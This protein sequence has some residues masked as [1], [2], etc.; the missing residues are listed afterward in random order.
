MKRTIKEVYGLIEEKLNNAKR[1]YQNEEFKYLGQKALLQGT[2]DAYQ[3]ILSLIESSHLLEEDKPIKGNGLEALERIGKEDLHSEREDYCFLKNVYAN[4]YNIIETALKEGEINKEALKI[5]ALVLDLNAHN[6]LV[7]S[8]ALE[9]GWIT[10]EEYE[11][12]EDELKRF[13]E[14]KDE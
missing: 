5:L 12:V 11:L 2:I 6:R 9:S 13:K 4:E 3:D 7:L 14:N 10:K 1:D 8:D